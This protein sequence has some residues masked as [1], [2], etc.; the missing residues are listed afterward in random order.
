MFVVTPS[1]IG[2]PAM[3][4]ALAARKLKPLNIT[5][6]LKSQREIALKRRYRRC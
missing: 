5:L 1:G 3:A 2:S 6:Q 4:G